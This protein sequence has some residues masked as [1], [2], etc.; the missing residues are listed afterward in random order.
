MP[1]TCSARRPP[2]STACWRPMEHN[3]PCCSPSWTSPAGI[4]TPTAECAF[5]VR[6]TF[7]S[8]PG[9]PVSGLPHPI[10][11]SAQ[12]ENASNDFFMTRSLRIEEH[13][14]PLHC[15]QYIVRGGGEE[16]RIPINNYWNGTPRTRR[17]DKAGTPG[18][19]GIPAS[20]SRRPV[21]KGRRHIGRVDRKTGDS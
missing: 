2:V 20:G 12:R 21:G 11:R 8:L 5:P 10:A 13:G 18:R 1:F 6:T 9:L 7:C 19:L 4:A 17:L 15:G 16:G 14:P 3:T